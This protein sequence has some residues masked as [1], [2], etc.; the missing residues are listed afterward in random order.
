VGPPA[1]TTAVVARSVAAR[2]PRAPPTAPVGPE[3]GVQG[4]TAASSASATAAVAAAATRAD[5]QGRTALGPSDVA[6]G[7]GW[8][9]RAV[10]RG[11]AR[12]RRR[13][14]HPYCN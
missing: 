1:V 9:E 7:A 12:R 8:D 11:E 3:S 6:A 14:G 5:R 13:S 4:A 10:A 2:A